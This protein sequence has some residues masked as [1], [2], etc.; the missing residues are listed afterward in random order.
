ML[1]VLYFFFPYNAPEPLC[2][3]YQFHMLKTST[4]A[5]K[6]YFMLVS[7]VIYAEGLLRQYK[8][9][10]TIF[11]VD[12]MRKGLSLA[13]LET[14]KSKHIATKGLESLNELSQQ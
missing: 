11:T 8:E 1:S 3:A 12:L 14:H 6:T 2:K 5:I 13:W 4:A 7:G 10:G 9:R